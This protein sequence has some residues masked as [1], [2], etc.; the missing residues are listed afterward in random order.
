MRITRDTVPFAICGP[1]TL[2]LHT[3]APNAKGP[4][5]RESSR[6]YRRTM[7]SVLA[8]HD[9]DDAQPSQ[10]PQYPPLPALQS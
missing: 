7:T 2:V 9:D 8:T 3:L 1:L 5:A 4:T 10:A 6:P